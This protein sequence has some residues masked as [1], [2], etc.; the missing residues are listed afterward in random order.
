MAPKLPDRGTPVLVV[1]EDAASH[2]TEF[3]DLDGKMPG[4]VE[5][6]YIG[7]YGGRRKNETLFYNEMDPATKE[8]RALNPIPTSCIKSITPME[9]RRGRA[10]ERR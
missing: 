9:P 4:L 1:W 2:G 5:L 6:V 7:F 3:Y 10:R 8:V